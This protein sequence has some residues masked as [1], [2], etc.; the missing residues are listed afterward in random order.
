MIPASCVDNF[1]DDPD[2]IRD[3]ALSLD[4]KS[5]DE[6]T[7]FPGLRTDC[8]STV[9]NNY[10]ESS[11]K[12][13]LSYFFDMT[14][15]ISWTGVSHFQKSFAFNENKSNLVNMGWAHRD[16]EHPLRTL[17]AVVYLNKNTYLGSGTS[18]LH[19]SI[20]HDKKYLNFS[21]RNK[22]YQNN[23]TDQNFYSDSLK[24][25]N[26]QFDVTVEFK[27]R[28][29]RMIA[30]DGHFWH[31]ESCLWVPEE[32]RL[33]QVFFIQFQKNIPISKKNPKNNLQYS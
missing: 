22:F 30:Y 25:H 18:I 31:R 24:K 2:S 28:Y 7:Y 29:N 33:T 21:L 14:S 15:D 8:L 13:L 5:P 4:Y 32:F 3:Y 1:W 20:N 27:N 16:D 17:S 11:V 23:Y 26:D 12:K 19:P 6:N 9:D 10:Y